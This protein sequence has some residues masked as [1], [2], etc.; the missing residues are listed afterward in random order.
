MELCRRRRAAPRQ[1]PGVEVENAVARMGSGGAVLKN[2][3][4]EAARPL[5]AAM[6]ALDGRRPDDG[7]RPKVVSSSECPV[8]VIAGHTARPGPRSGGPRRRSE[9]SLQAV[10]FAAA[11]ADRGGDELTVVLAFQEPGPVGREPAAV[12]RARRDDRRG[13]PMVLAESVAGLGDKYRTSWSISGSK[14][15]PNPP[16]SSIA[17]GGPPPGDRQP[18]P[19]RLLP[20]GARLH[21]PRRAAERALPH[22]CH[23]GAQGQA[24]G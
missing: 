14:R 24:R 13:G 18:R 2:V 5:S 16:S 3:D 23:P 4:K 22:H 9:E 6:T 1:V 21:G 12:K 7:P 20:D 19:R 10:S 11:E 17:A 8:T 15:T